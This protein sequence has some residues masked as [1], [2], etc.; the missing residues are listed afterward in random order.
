MA[1]AKTGLNW[2]TPYT[3]G[4]PMS[5]TVLMLFPKEMVALKQAVAFMDAR[6]KSRG[7]DVTE[8]AE[9]LRALKFD[10]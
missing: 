1:E 8:L 6:N 2:E 9:I 4:P 10:E 3:G 7:R 5:V